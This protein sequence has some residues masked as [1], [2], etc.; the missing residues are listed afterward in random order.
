M[1][2]ASEEDAASAVRDAVSSGRTLAVRGG[3]TRDGL[4]RP[5]EASA[6]LSVAGLTGITLYEPAE[7]VIGAWAGT[8]VGTIV[9]ALAA[10][11]QMLPVEPMDHRS[12]YGTAGEPTLGGLVATNAS[13][14]RRV[15]AGAIRDHLIGVRFVNGRGEIVK[16]GGRVMK[17]V[18]GLD[19]VKLQCGAHGTLGV[20]TEVVFKVLPSPQSTASLAWSGLDDHRAIAALTMALGSP[21]ELSGA[22]HLPACASRGAARTLLRLEGFE[23]EVAHRLPRIAALLA[24]F[25]EAERIDAEASV[26]LWAGIRDAAPLAAPPESVVWRISVP[27]THGPEVIDRLRGSLLDHYYDWGGGLVWIAAPAD[28][29]SA[30]GI[31]RAAIRSGHATLIR[32]PDELRRRTSVFDPLLP[33]LLRV[34][35]DIKAALD[36]EAILNPGRMYAGV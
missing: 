22:A 16:S 26:A 19:L 8:P 28:H 7:L 1:H 6:V 35:R 15:K 14:P 30:A 32:A 27:P 36:P 33:G 21:F 2:P 34:S 24:A 3:G 13:G 5:V 23:D 9:D 25:G 18:T 20:L 11:G 31:I 12:L 10:R 29:D 17:N 4:G